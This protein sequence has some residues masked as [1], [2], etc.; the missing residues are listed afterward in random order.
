MNY[1]VLCILILI[2]RWTKNHVKHTK[3]FTFMT[4]HARL[5]WMKNNCVLGSVK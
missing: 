1:K 2:F 4:F 5:L 3:I